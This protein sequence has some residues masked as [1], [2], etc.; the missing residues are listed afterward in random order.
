[1]D[2]KTIQTKLRS[3]FKDDKSYQRF[4]KIMIVAGLAVIGLVVIFSTSNSVPKKKKAPVKNANILNKSNFD[5]EQWLVGAQ[6]NMLNMQKQNAANNKKIAIMQKEL[7]DYSV[8]NGGNGGGSGIPGSPEFR[9]AQ[10]K[11]GVMP[12]GRGS[13]VYPPVPGAG[14]GHNMPYAGQAGGANYNNG[15]PAG[16]PEAVKVV[17]VLNPLQVI[18]SVPDSAPDVTATAAGKKKVSTGF[19]IEPGTFTQGLLLNGM[20]APANMK[21]KSN[22]YPSLIRLTNL[23]FVP[24]KYRMD[25]RN[26]FV[27]VEG[28]GSLS[29]DRVYMRTVTL[30]CTENGG[31][32]HIVAPI[33][34]YIVGHHGKLGL[35]GKV[36][37]KQGAILAR[38]LLAGMLQG[39][40]NVMS[41]SSETTTTSPL[42]ASSIINPSEVGSAA[43]GQGLS[44]AA[45]GLS[46][47]YLKLAN[48]MVPV[49]AV[50]AG[51]KVTIVITKGIF[52]QK[53]PNVEYGVV[54]ST[55]T[56]KSGYA[57]NFHVTKKK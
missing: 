54:G 35:R 17:P 9:T 55:K 29:S 6:R 36:V 1:M 22:P 51:R 41:M 20:D 48:S 7:H 25:M 53:K 21:G 43:I 39:A 12:G 19:Y 14:N 49:V 13:L 2:F 16:K 33:S 57:T 40:G 11:N 47:F 32:Y 44:T 28:Y 52:V 5:K 10:N 3:K 27:L 46:K 23:S 4:I 31:K 42:G 18:F 8:I 45:E 50:G 15:G 24:N 30:S 34:G 37:S 56:I 38:D 26:C